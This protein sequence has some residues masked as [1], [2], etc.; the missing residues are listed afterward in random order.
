MVDVNQTIFCDTVKL[1]KNLGR[2]DDVTST[3]T[4]SSSNLLGCKHV[5]GEDT[6]GLGMRTIVGH[7]FTPTHLHPFDC[8]RTFSDSK[9]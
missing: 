2:K 9:N 6:L 3:Q 1:C 7:V 8:E 5:L 4:V